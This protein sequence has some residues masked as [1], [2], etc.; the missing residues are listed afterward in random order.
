MTDSTASS[1]VSFQKSMPL[2][3]Q[4]FRDCMYMKGSSGV[5]L[6]GE[7]GASVGEGIDVFAAAH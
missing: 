7:L 1:P 6:R 2:P 4:G 5:P 3:L